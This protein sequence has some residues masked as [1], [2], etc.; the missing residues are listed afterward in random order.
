MFVSVLGRSYL[1][2]SKNYDSTSHDVRVYSRTFFG[3]SYT[4]R[5]SGLI[6]QDA[7][8]AVSC[9]L[10]SRCATLVCLIDRARKT[11]VVLEFF[12]SQ[13]GY[14]LTVTKS[15]Q[16]LVILMYAN[17]LFGCSKYARPKSMMQHPNRIRMVPGMVNQFC[18]VL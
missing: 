15:F 10:D 4:A 3:W 8:E 12:K 18:T 13:N 9:V 14:F 2:F 11:I 5:D 16:V 1:N 17:P 6:I 7:W